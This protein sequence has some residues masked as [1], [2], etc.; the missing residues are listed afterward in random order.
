MMPWR[1][2]LA[3][4]GVAGVILTAAVFVGVRLATADPGGPASPDALTFAGVLR[5]RAMRSTTLTFVFR[6]GTTEVC[7]T[8]TRSFMPDANGAFSE[9]VPMDTM[10]CPRSLFD[11]AT[12]TYDVL[13]DGE[14]TPIASGVEVTPVPYAR[15]AD[16]VGINND[17]PIGYES[18]TDSYFTRES[19]RRLCQKSRMEG[20]TRIVYDEVVRVGRGSAVFWIDRWEATVTERDF[21]GTRYGQTRADYP[22]VEFPVN[23]QWTE[24]RFALSMPRAA[25]E[26]VPSRFISWFQAS[27]AC[28]INGK[29]L[30][31]GEEWL[32]AARGTP[33]NAA[34]CNVGPADVRAPETSGCRSSWGAQDMVGNL[35]EWTTEWYAGAG[36]GVSADFSGVQL[37][38]A[39]TR[40][41]LLP[42]PAQRTATPW[43]IEYNGDMTENVN[44]FVNRTSG[45]G[46]AGMPAAAIRGGARALGDRAGT[47]ALSLFVG[48]SHSDELVGFRCVI[49]R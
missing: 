29:R 42:G 44:G 27:S 37:V 35:W 13:L 23:G 2:Y 1:T 30:P 19:G 32:T 33:D 39:G 43:P 24:E 14:T 26:H 21:G 28:R 34:F 10:R 5:E 4:V 38:D 41:V 20:A 8:M 12:V 45:I 17:C 47:F 18:V 3:R 15:F 31:S 25:V 46:V 36:H 49:P 9:R 6:K 40:P 11:G 7:R 48:P 16:Q 22:A